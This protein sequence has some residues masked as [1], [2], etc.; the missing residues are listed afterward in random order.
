MYGR[1][2]STTPSCRFWF[3]TPR[4]N[5]APPPLRRGRA[6]CYRQRFAD[7]LMRAKPMRFGF[8]DQL[9]CASGFTEAQRY[10][11]ILDQI[12]CGDA[13]GFDTAWLGELHFSRPFSIL[14]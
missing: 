12:D 4:V 9:P 8:F 2:N 11:D 10:R 6:A 3:P 14:A 1:A 7:H 5:K 13:L